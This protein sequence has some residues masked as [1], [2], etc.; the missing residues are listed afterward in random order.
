MRILCVDDTK[1]VHAFMRSL[2][3]GTQHNIVDVFD[4]QEALEV[5][6]REGVSAF[7]LVLLDWEMPNKNGMDTLIELRKITR[8]L[9]VIMVTSKND[10]QDITRLLDAGASEYVMK[11]FTRDILFDKIVQVVGKEVA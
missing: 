6:N 9:P 5:I 11:P 2:F 4:G 8:V 10:V 1:A 3:A 7:D